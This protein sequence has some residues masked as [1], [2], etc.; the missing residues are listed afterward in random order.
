MKRRPPRKQLIK[1]GKAAR[2]ILQERKIILPPEQSAVNKIQNTKGSPILPGIPA[3]IPYPWTINAARRVVRDLGRSWL[4]EIKDSDKRKTVGVEFFKYILEG[5]N[6]PKSKISILITETAERKEYDMKY[7]SRKETI[8][9]LRRFMVDCFAIAVIV[10]AHDDVA[11][12][13]EWFL[14]WSESLLNLWPANIRNI[15]GWKDIKKN[16]SDKKNNSIIQT[17]ANTDR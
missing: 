9:A 6:R 17:T 15:D 11:E 5:L 1:A 13:L 16:D 8:D 4:E 3:Y 14:Q 12:F 10:K 2:E 7:L